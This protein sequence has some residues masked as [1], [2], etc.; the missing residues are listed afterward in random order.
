MPLTFLHQ[1]FKL[2]IVT[3]LLILGAA[4]QPAL[5]NDDGYANYH[6]AKVT[7][8]EPLTRMIEHR[9]PERHCWNEEV[10]YEN[11]FYRPQSVTGTI[12]GGI[13]GG[14][15][16]NALGHKKRNKQIGTAVGAILGASIG[17]DLSNKHSRGDYSTRRRG[18]EQ[19][20]EVSHRRYFEEEIIG[21]QV[22]YRYRGDTYS[23]RMSHKPGKKIRV[24]VT[25]EPA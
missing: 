6:W 21:Y 19:R 5:A 1:T 25:V 9:E 11:S 24:K 18:H 14:A 17:N 7:R 10:E 3:T 15:V 22:W 2:F 8:V 23:T 16:G 12:V 20:C 4:L 13:I